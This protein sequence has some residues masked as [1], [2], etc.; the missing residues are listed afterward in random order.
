MTYTAL[1]R[2][3]SQSGGKMDTTPAPPRKPRRGV[4]RVGDLSEPSR[5]GMGAN[6]R[7]ESWSGKLLTERR[8]YCIIPV[9]AV[10]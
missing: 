4:W 1:L 6:E 7:R 5:G 2:F 3:T 9:E 8:K 10:V